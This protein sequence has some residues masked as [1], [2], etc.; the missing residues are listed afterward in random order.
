MNRLKMLPAGPLTMIALVIITGAPFPLSATPL[1][2]CGSP[3]SGFT[4]CPD[5]EFQN[6]RSQSESW[7][8]TA[9]DDGWEWVWNW[10]GSFLEQED[11]ENA[12]AQYCPEGGGGGQT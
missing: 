7:T 12:T 4:W 8:C 10:S 9:E 2:S 5:C 11:G 3:N 1:L 6:Q